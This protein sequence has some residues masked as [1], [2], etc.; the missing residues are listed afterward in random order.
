MWV[1]HTGYGIREYCKKPNKHKS[2]PQGPETK[3]RG[4]SADGGEATLAT[5]TPLAR[6]TEPMVPLQAHEQATPFVAGKLNCFECPCLIGHVDRP[7]IED[8]LVGWRTHYGRSGLLF[9]SGRIPEEAAWPSGGGGLLLACAPCLGFGMGRR[10]P[11]DR[12]QVRR[13]LHVITSRASPPRF[14]VPC[15]FGRASN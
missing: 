3:Q 10:P 1:A 4:R 14:V 2:Q 7:L 15:S 9:Y 5:S 11:T 12:P 8:R 6:R 13:R